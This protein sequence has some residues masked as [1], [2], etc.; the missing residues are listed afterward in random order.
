MIVS[1]VEKDPTINYVNDLNYPNIE[2]VVCKISEHPGKGAK[3][4]YF[5]LNKALEKVTTK[6]VSYFSS[7]DIIYPTKS[8]NEIK[9][10][11]TEN[12]IFC[13]SKF[14]LVNPE[15]QAK[16]PYCYKKKMNYENLLTGNY[17]NDC[18]TIDITKLDSPLQFNYIKYENTCYRH[19]WL[20][21]LQKNGEKCMSINDNIEW[22][23]IRDISKSQSLQ[24]N[25]NNAL[26]NRELNIRKYMLSTFLRSDICEDDYKN[27]HAERFWWYND[28]DLNS[29]YKMAV[30]VNE[31][32]L[33]NIIDILENKFGDILYEI[34][35]FSQKSN[36]LPYLTIKNNLKNLK[37]CYK[38]TYLKNNIID[39]YLLSE[40]K[41]IINI[42]YTN[43][44]VLLVHKSLL[45]KVDISHIFL[46][47]DIEYIKCI[48]NE[49][50]STHLANNI[51]FFILNERGVYNFNNIFSST[52]SDEIKSHLQQDIEQFV[53]S[54]TIYWIK[55][56]FKNI[57][58][59][60]ILAGKFNSKKKTKIDYNLVT[61]LIGYY[62]NE[63]RQK[64]KDNFKNKIYI[65]WGGSDCL[66][67]KKSRNF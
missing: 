25:T 58:K 62:P 33:L 42:E 20:S 11:Q 29:N 43:N 34:I 45:N 10:I 1:T 40:D 23:Y 2:L 63:R 6:Y 24:R 28:I 8:Y 17:I 32:D 37:K 26:K 47:H 38:I 14:L 39:W 7:N 46:K 44:N 59:P 60:V 9:K 61:L 52:D 55:D 67:K 21:L 3:G 15:T 53:L 36:M 65:L 48:I 12:T 64:L 16:K 51:N 4:I 56:R 54:I 66:V 41:S 31:D 5:Q 13:F 35:C 27:I 18:A 57:K 30:F 49:F 22:E 50:N 19:L